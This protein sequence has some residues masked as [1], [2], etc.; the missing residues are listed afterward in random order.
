MDFGYIYYS[1]NEINGKMYIGK[2]TT[3]SLH[4]ENDYKG[5]GIDLQKTLKEYGTKN[6]S[7]HFLAAAQS[8]EE[9]TRLE[10][11]YLTYYKIPNE[12]FYNKNLATSNSDQS[13]YYNKN[14]QKGINLRDVICYNLKDNSLTIFNNFTA[15]CK[16][17]NMI[18]GNIFNVISGQRITHKDCIF[19]YKDYPLS[20]DGINWI[21]N[22]KNKT[23]YKTKYI[24]IDEVKEELKSNYNL[25]NNK[26]ID[27]KFNGYYI[28]D[29]KELTLNWEEINSEEIERLIDK[30]GTAPKEEETIGK[31]ELNKEI[32]NKFELPRDSEFVIV[33]NGKTLYFNYD[34]INILTKLYTD[35]NPRILRQALNR[36]QRTVM[37]KQYSIVY[38]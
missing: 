27:F 30:E 2:I 11:Y 37:N 17:H 23:N 7:I 29:N 14:N 8:S 20:E 28:E 12:K 31:L 26:D 35:I 10:K 3:R 25:A 13:N 38:S 5:S 36:K 6:F 9:L 16:E 24:K 32:D 22:Y 1:K 15:F 19:W 18:R 34:E 4:W 21:V 33:G